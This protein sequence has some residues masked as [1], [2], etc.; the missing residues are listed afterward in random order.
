M[1]YT[2][3]VLIGDNDSSFN[4]VLDYWTAFAESHQVGFKRAAE[5]LLEHFLRDIKNAAGDRDT[6]ILPI[7]FLFRHYLEIRFKEI[8]ASGITLLGESAAWPLGHNLIKL[9]RDCRG[10]CERIYGENFSDQLELVHK[11]VED[12]NYLDQT[13]ENFR[14]PKDKN[15][16]PPFKQEV[17]SLRILHDVI[18][19]VGNFLEGISMEIFARREYLNER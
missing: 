9:W 5:L 17:I 3:R 14:Y 15:G 18:R 16:N 7:L 4:A 11:C 10:V 6:L 19:D 2:M 8:T 13:S 1:N 12:L